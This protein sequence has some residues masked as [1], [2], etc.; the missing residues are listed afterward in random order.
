MTTWQITVNE[1]PVGERMFS[2][3]EGVL[4][5]GSSRECEIRSET[6]GVAPRH[7]EFL[8]REG[9]LQLRILDGGPGALRAPD[10]QGLQAGTRLG[11][12]GQ[13]R[14]RQQQADGDR[15]RGGDGEKGFDGHGG[16]STSFGGANSRAREC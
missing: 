15:E 1:A 13:G 11:L 5:L 12:V 8:G 4:L 2:L 3:Q 10:I 9:K 7:A 16:F 6:G 14:T